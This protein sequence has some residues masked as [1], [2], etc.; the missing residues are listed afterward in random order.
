MPTMI[1]RPCGLVFCAWS[2]G[3]TSVLTPQEAADMLDTL[4]LCLYAAECREMAI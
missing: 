2:N 4:A 1:E 3:E